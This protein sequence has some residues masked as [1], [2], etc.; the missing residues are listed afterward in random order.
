VATRLTAPQFQRL[1]ESRDAQLGA[2]SGVEY[3]EGLIVREP[4]LRPHLFKEWRPPFS[5]AEASR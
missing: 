4:V 3:A 5:P 2:R 1:I